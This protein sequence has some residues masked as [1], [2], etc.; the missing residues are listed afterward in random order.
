MTEAS[1]VRIFRFPVKSMGGEE[2]ES[3]EVDSTGLVGDR[4]WAVYDQAGKLASGKHSRRFKRMDPVF[5]LTAV[6][7][8]DQVLIG[9]PGGERVVA[10]EGRADLALS[11]HFGE[12]VEL[13][14]E[15]DVPHQDAG[16][17]SLVGTATLR[18][19]G[20]LHGTEP[21]DPRHLRAN[22]VL[23]T[24]EPFVEDS[25]V[26]REI[27]IGDIHLAVTERIERCRMVD[28]AQVGLAPVEGLLTTI[29]RERQVC[30]GVYAA[31]VQ[32]G[33]LALGALAST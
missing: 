15:A 31:I 10:G 29:G 33:L 17:I 20:R 3:V 4:A 19:L 24:D 32:P 1:V 26:G 9:L 12:E 22:V 13:A 18:E 7:D 5:A 30:A 21:I 2:L 27:A 16:Q 25:W 6:T 23:E 28:I 14:T 8:G 11:D